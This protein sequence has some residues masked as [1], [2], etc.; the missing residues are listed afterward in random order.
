A[1][2]FLS[3]LLSII[4]TDFIFAY[5]SFNAS[6]DFFSILI[7]SSSFCS[8]L[9]S[10]YIFPPVPIMAAISKKL[11]ITIIHFLFISLILSFSQDKFC[12]PFYFH[13]VPRFDYLKVTTLI[14]KKQWVYQNY[15]F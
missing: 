13:T 9:L 1:P 10:I 8:V 15:P 6:I 4:S 7:F 14:L 2:V 12:S 11:I 3:I 5:L